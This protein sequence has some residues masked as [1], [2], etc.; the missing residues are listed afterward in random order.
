MKRYKLS[1]FELYSDD[2]GEDV[3]L[4]NNP[5]GKCPANINSLPDY[6]GNQTNFGSCKDC[7]IYDGRVDTL[8][9]A[10]F[11]RRSQ[12]SFLKKLSK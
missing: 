8:C 9:S 11:K 1:D 3:R 7:P 5:N 4:I 2:T 12:L 10:V 6:K